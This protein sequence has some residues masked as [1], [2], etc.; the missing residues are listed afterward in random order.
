MK[1]QEQIEAR[2]KLINYVFGN[3]VILSNTELNYDADE[4][5]ASG[6]EK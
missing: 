6:D 3:R 5:A 4:N 1:T 2:E